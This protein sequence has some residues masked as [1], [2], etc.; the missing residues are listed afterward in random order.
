ML[1]FINVMFINRILSI[2]FVL[3]YF[4]VSSFLFLCFTIVQKS[5]GGVS[6]RTSGNACA[7]TYECIIHMYIYIYI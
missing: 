7:N 3:S 2:L 1:L 4:C 6:G 5:F